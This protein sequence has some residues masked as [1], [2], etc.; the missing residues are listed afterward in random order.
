V[1]FVEIFVPRN[2]ADAAYRALRKSKKNDVL[3]SSLAQELIETNGDSGLRIFLSTTSKII[4]KSVM[5]LRE[6]CLLV[7]FEFANHF[8]WAT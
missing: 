6:V 1:P 4:C 7:P 2:C 5:T 8:H 3:V